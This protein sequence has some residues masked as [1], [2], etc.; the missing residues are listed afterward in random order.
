MLYGTLDGK[1]PDVECQDCSR[2]DDTQQSALDTAA[3]KEHHGNGSPSFP[4]QRLLGAASH[5]S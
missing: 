5:A 1:A 3:L 2:G 4:R